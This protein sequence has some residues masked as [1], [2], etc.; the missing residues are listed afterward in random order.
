VKKALGNRGEEIAASFLRKQ[1]YKVLKRNYSVPTGEIDIIA[2]DGGTLVFVEVKTR[3]GDRFGA[4]AEA[5]GARK[6]RRMRSAA[7]H[8]MAGLKNEPPARFDIVSVLLGGG[9]EDVQHMADAFETEEG[10]C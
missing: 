6:R 9:R 1:G 10:Q 2:R 8:Y 4:P 7:L 5:V 3:T